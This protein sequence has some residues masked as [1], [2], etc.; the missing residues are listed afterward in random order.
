MKIAV[1]GWGSLIWSP[2]NLRIKT[3]WRSDGPR[4]PIEFA[5]ISRDGRVTLVIL[6]RAKKQAVYWAL[7]A[8]DD[9]G[10]AR[11]N[12]KE[13]EG[14]E[15]KDIHWFTAKGETAADIPETVI[16][17]VRSWLRSH[18]QVNA[19]IWTGLTTNW[20]EK[21]GQKFASK[22]AVRYLKELKPDRDGAETTFNRAQEYVKNAPSLIQTRVRRAMQQEGW[23]VAEL[24]KVLFED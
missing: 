16:R 19:V 12:L 5:R 6:P 2:R 7:S 17:S 13:R 8:F 14:S 24:S 3:K 10:K 4:L 23:K 15:S 11:Q 22:D 1:L 18:Q 21:R 9:L 20:Q